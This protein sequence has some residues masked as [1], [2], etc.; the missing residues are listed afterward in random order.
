MAGSLDILDVDEIE[1]KIG[2]LLK[3]ARAVV[4]NVIEIPDLEAVAH[5]D[6]QDMPRLAP[7]LVEP[8]GDGQ[9]A[10]A[11]DAG[12][13]GETEM[14]AQPVERVGRT[15][16]AADNLVAGEPLDTLIE[17]NLIE[18]DQAVEMVMQAEVQ[19]VACAASG[20][21]GE[22]RLGQRHHAPGS[23]LANRTP[24]EQSTH[25]LSPGC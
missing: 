12:G 7:A 25:W 13:G 11:V 15:G 5:A 6:E 21:G 16:Q 2:Q 4:E 20:D 17:Q 22:E 10:L 3:I 8:R 24:Y 9:A 14:A 23:D 18:Q 19:I 1:V